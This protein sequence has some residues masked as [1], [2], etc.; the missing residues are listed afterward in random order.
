[1]REEQV[2]ELLQHVQIIDRQIDSETGLCT[3]KAVMQK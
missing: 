3:S 1:V 2:S